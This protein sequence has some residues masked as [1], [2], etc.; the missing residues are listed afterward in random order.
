MS[1][2]T[3]FLAKL[4]GLYSLV[5]PICMITH[6][7]TMVEAVTE[8][9]RS[10]ALML[11]LGVF[12]LAAGLA[13]GPDAQCLVGW[14]IA[15]RDHHRG[16]AVGDEGPGVPVAFARNGDASVP[17]ESTLRAEFLFLHGVFDRDRRVPDVLRIRVEETTAKVKHFPAHACATRPARAKAM[18]QIGSRRANRLN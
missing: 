6:K 11:V 12:T 3:I 8:I 9:L 7:Q 18:T 1:T 10:P 16:L 2:R 17:D 5:A 15:R 4:V 14:S 13:M